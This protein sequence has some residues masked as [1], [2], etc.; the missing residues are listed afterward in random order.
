MFPD[1]LNNKKIIYTFIIIII[2]VAIFMIYKKKNENFNSVE[3]DNKTTD[4]GNEIILYYS[5]DCGYSV[6][7]LPEWNKFEKYVQE[8]LPQLNISK[9]SCKG[10]D[11]DLCIQKQIKGYPT[12]M[13]Y[14]N[15]GS[16][17]QFD[18]ARSLD[19]L[20]NFVNINLNL[21]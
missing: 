12:V 19:N 7:F 5:M 9:I 1:I 4:S 17:I 13:F 20:I 18:E 8:N 3:N 16:E 10:S 21:S 11:E 6:Q 14:K 15:D 2:L